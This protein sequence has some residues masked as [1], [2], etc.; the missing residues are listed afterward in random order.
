MPDKQWIK[1]HIVSSVWNS[2]RD[3]ERHGVN[4][5]TVPKV[6]EFQLNIWNRNDPEVTEEV[7]STEIK[8]LVETGQLIEVNGELR[9]GTPIFEEA[10][11]VSEQAKAAA[12]KIWSDLTDRRGVKVELLKCD[13]AVIEEIKNTHA[14]LI[15][16]AFGTT[17]KEGS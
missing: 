11:L 17:P 16:Q 12:E 5:L 9:T 6:I 3:F 14:V 13:Q 1:K 8:R 4:R 10:K 2:D 15:D 7:V